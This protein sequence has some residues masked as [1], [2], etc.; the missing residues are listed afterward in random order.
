MIKNRISTTLPEGTDIQVFKNWIKLP[1][2]EDDIAQLIIDAIFEYLDEFLNETLLAS[3]FECKANII[4][5]GNYID[6][7]SYEPLNVVITKNNGDV[8]DGWI[9]NKNIILLDTKK[10]A[11]IDFLK[12]T[13]STNALT[14]VSPTLQLIINAMFAYMQEHRGDCEDAMKSLS[15]SQQNELIKLQ[16]RA[17]M[18]SYE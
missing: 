15:G 16:N 4:S 2:L 18:V 12:I 17:E 10:I 11:E 3:S 7:M 14:E 9:Q 6:L 8:F 13:Y 1:L 5:L